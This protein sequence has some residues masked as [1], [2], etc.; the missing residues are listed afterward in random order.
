MVN[1][2]WTYSINLFGPEEEEQEEDGLLAKVP[3]KALEPK[4]P[5]GGAL[6][7][8]VSDR[9]DPDIIRTPPSRKPG[10]KSDP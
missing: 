7:T 6:S 8:R 9:F 3:G 10:S 2:S 4:S 5:A 1:T